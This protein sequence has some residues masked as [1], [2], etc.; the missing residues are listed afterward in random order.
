LKRGRYIKY[1]QEID[2]KFIE[3]FNSGLTYANMVQPMNDAK[4]LDANGNEI[5]FSPG[6]VRGRMDKLTDRG[7]IKPRRPQSR[8]SVPKQEKMKYINK[9]EPEPET[10]EPETPET[11]KPEIE[12]KVNDM[13]MELSQPLPPPFFDMEIKK[14]HDKLC[15]H[16]E[17]TMVYDRKYMIHECANNECPH[18]IKLGVVAT[19]WFFE[20]QAQ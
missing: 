7:W 20:E 13:Q 14:S 10:P 2:E 18:F 6:M 5:S 12:T 9:P 1:T 3:L 19:K 4:L 11:F 17:K 15:D 8:K 16:C